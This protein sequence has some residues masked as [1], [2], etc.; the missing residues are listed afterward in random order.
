MGGLSESESFFFYL[1]SKTV[2]RY[3]N[4]SVSKQSIKSPSLSS[5]L[6]AKSSVKV[7]GRAK[8]KLIKDKYLQSFSSRAS[9]LT[10]NFLDNEELG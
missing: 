2:D 4:A 6:Q 7:P 1:V 5:Y 9:N 10:L 3:H 8:S